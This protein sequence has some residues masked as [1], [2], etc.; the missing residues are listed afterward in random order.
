VGSVQRFEGLL[1]PVVAVLIA[2]LIGVV[3]IL[4]VGGSPIEAYFALW[5]AN[6][7]SLR[8][9]GETLVTTTPLIFTGLAVALA[10]RCGLFNIG[11]EGQYLAAQM[12]A[13]IVG[14]SIVL[15]GWI[16]LPLV[17]LGGAL[18]GALWAAIPGLL[19]AYRGVHEV[20][21]T[22]MM[23]YVALHLLNFLLTRYLKA[24]GPLP[25]SP[26]IHPSAQ[27]AQGLIAGSRFHAGFFFALLVAVAVY[28]LLFRTTLGY[29][30]RAV[31]LAPGAAEYG[32]INIKKMTVVAMMIS[33]ALCG[34]AGAIQVA[35]IQ[36]RYYDAFVWP[37]FGFDGIAVALLGRN[38]P[39]G[40][41]VAALLF[42]ILERGA[43]AIQMMSGVPKSVVD[44]VQGVVIFL[45][46]ADLIVRNLIIRRRA[47]EVKAA[48]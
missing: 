16:H 42:G 23:N 31:G 46:A 20:I 4:M 34:M 3:F 35:G 28:F 40:V 5:T 29:S 45:V 43:P 25:V 2:L 12:L 18:G 11:G 37:G 22:I 47:R 17:I 10:F 26:E 21:N 7:G 39:L 14:F 6:F 27:I 30:I 41:I 44:V 15:P 9:F 13:A 33:G 48:A 19:K 36:H 38:H 32:G 8:A 24:P 1:V